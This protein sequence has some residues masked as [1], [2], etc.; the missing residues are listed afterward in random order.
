MSYSQLFG[1]SAPV[2][3]LT[4]DAFIKFQL[5]R[6]MLE[7]NGTAPFLKQASKMVKE[8]NPQPNQEAFDELIASSLQYAREQMQQNEIYSS[9]DEEA[10]SVVFADIAAAFKKL[11]DE[12]RQQGEGQPEAS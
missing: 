5:K 8:L 3:E 10:R 6:K 1:D 9:Y 11:A 7:A 4:L 2:W 12:T